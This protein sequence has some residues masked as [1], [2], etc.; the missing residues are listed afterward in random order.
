MGMD[1]DGWFRTELDDAENRRA[2]RALG[3]LMSEPPNDD[4]DGCG[5]PVTTATEEVLNM[6]EALVKA[7]G[8][9]CDDLGMRQLDEVLA[10]PE[11]HTY[12]PSDD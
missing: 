4:G 2:E 3:E 6:D 12:R 8:A 10:D 7:L 1:N 5:Q 11:Q 9:M